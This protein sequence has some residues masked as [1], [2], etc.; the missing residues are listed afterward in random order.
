MH[1]GAKTLN[2]GS[3]MQIKLRLRQMGVTDRQT[4]RHTDRHT[5]T[6]THRHT[7]TQTDTQ[8]HIH[9]DTQTA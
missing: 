1:T 3:E 5:D 9:T 2:H 6:Q 8:T 7:D 4:H